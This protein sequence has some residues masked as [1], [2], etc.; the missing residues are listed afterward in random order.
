[1]PCLQ[2]WKDQS[3]NDPDVSYL[4][5]QIKA[6]AVVSYVTLQN[7]GYYRQWTQHTLEVDDDLLYNWEHPKA[8]LIRQLRRRV[9]PTTLQQVIYTAYHASPMA[10]HVGFYKTYWRITARYFWPGM[11]TDIRNAV[12]ECG[13]CILGNNVSHKAQQVLDSLSVDEPF[14]IIAI[15]IWVPGVTSARGSLPED[16][17]T[18][19][20]A[21]LTSLCN[22]TSFATVGFLD[23][24]D[25]D[26]VTQ[27]ILSQVMI[28]N[29]LPKLVLMDTDSL[30]KTSLQY[31]LC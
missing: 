18:I 26:T 11:Y 5:K 24:L 10:G 12:L 4:I 25:S 28:P 7:K 3:A 21:M 20:K 6:G 8:A 13:H 30:F 22:L 14:D 29:G 2:E 17:S 19:K 27:V 9:V 23:S 15:D 16:Q 31:M 1:M